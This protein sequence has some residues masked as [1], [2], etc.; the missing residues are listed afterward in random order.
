MEVTVNTLNVLEAKVKQCEDKITKLERQVQELV[1][2][3]TQLKQKTKN[4]T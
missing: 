4:E 1:Q 3:V 2:T